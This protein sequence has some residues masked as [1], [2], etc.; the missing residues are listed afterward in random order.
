METRA[1]FW[2][3]QSFWTTAFYVIG[4]AALGVFFWEAGQDTT[5]DSQHSLINAARQVAN[6]FAADETK[7]DGAKR[8]NEKKSE[9]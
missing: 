7:S 1:L 3:L 2:G 9:L 5:S 4:F 6:S 8:N